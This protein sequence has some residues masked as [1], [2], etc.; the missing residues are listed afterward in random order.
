MYTGWVNC[1]KTTIEYIFDGKRVGK[2][3]TMDNDK[4]KPIYKVSIGRFPDT[5]DTYFTSWKMAV[6][7]LLDRV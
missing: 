7:S 3:R 5:E 4:G 2:I 1:S 6:D